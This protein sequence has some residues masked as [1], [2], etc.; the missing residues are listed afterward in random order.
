MLQTDDTRIYINQ[1]SLTNMHEMGEMIGL[2][3]GHIQ[4]QP[5]SIEI[6]ELWN[7]ETL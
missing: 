4:I 1:P 2:Q 6:I 3:L 5:S 7:L